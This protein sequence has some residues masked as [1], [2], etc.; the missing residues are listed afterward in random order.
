MPEAVI[1]SVARTPIGRAMKGSLKNERPDDLTAFI[2]DDVLNHLLE[3]VVAPVLSH[4]VTHTGLSLV[5]TRHDRLGFARSAV[6]RIVLLGA[7]VR[8][9]VVGLGAV[10]LVGVT[11]LGG[12]VFRVVLRF[13]LRRRCPCLTGR[14]GLRLLVLD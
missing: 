13:V 3:M 5:V 4:P 7:L 14:F 1:V 10:A 8:R 6:D 2:V 11:L 12:R 9:L